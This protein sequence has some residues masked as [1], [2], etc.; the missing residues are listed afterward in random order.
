MA[1]RHAD[2]HANLG[3][4]KWVVDAYTLALATTVLT[5]GSLADRFGRRAI[6]A[7]GLVVFTVSSL[8]CAL[9]NSIAMLDAA[10]VVQGIGASGL[11]A[12]SL[13]LLVNAYPEARE[14]N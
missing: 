11:F 1:R 4:L 9:S 12:S 7:A 6:F 8:A 2:R 10:R 3:A 13:A 5:I 14:R